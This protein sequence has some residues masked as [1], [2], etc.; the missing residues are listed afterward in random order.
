MYCY[1]RFR[2]VQ[3]LLAVPRMLLPRGAKLAAAAAASTAESAATVRNAVLSVVYVSE[4]VN[5]ALLDT[6]ADAASTTTKGAGLLRQF[7]DTTYHRTGYTI[8][9]SC[10]SSVADASIEVSR[11]ALRAIDLRMHE[12]SHPRIGVVDHVSVHPLGQGAQEAARE[13]GMA[14]ARALG[15]E[16][17]PVLLYGD[18]KKGRGLAEVRPATNNLNRRVRK[19]GVL[20]AHGGAGQP[21]PMTWEK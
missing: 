3:V 15:A 19:H 1:Q 6:L 5:T 18:L 12:A 11:R 13:A 8:G 9:G 14:I 17:L 21:F 20:G 10:P 2:A 7:R 16:G 4:G